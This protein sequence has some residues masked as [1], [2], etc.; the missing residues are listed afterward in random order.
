M[1]PSDGISNESSYKNLM[2]N[3]IKQQQKNGWE[4]SLMSTPPGDN[5]I[6]GNNRRMVQYSPESTLT[7]SSG[8]S[9]WAIPKI[10]EFASKEYN[11]GQKKSK[12]IKFEFGKNMYLV[13]M[14]FNPVTKAPQFII[15]VVGNLMHRTLLDSNGQPVFVPAGEMLTERNNSQ[16]GKAAKTFK[17]NQEK[18]A[19]RKKRLIEKQEELYSG[20]VPSEPTVM[21]GGTV[22]VQ[23]AV[24]KAQ[25]ELNP[26]LSNM[27]GIGTQQ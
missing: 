3:A 22:S 2:L 4:D 24:D 13:P 15:N 1:I 5:I 18:L 25:E 8:S 14:G 17:E 7:D 20:G 11:K 27:P 21:G 9:D 16:E 26:V 10:E 6:V 19:L 12:H 23:E